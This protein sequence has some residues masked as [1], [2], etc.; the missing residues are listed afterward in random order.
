[1]KATIANLRIYP[2][3]RNGLKIAEE[4]LKDPNVTT[5][6]GYNAQYEYLLLDRNTSIGSYDYSY[7]KGITPILYPIEYISK[8]I[9]HPI[10]TEPFI[11]IIEIAK[12]T[13]PF[14]E[15]ITETELGHDEDINETWANVLHKG[16]VIWSISF[17][18]VNFNC[19]IEEYKKLMDQ[20]KCFKLLQEFFINFQNIDALNPFDLD[21]N[22][23][24]PKI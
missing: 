19:G 9:Y 4:S 17:D 18:G 15:E 3:G 22:P 8:E 20:Y 12:Q 2:M 21:V 11:P 7:V 6:M 10:I 5:A 1:M 13:C 24:M 16:V 14:S 23:Y